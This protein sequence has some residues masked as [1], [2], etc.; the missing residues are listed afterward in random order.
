AYVTGGVSY[1][2]FETTSKAPPFEAEQGVFVLKLNPA[3]SGLDY[4]VVLG[5]GT[6]SGI[7]L[8]ALGDAYIVGYTN[9]SNFPTTVGAFQTQRRNAA[10]YLTDAFIARISERAEVRMATHVSAAN[11]GAPLAADSMI[12]AFGSKLAIGTEAALATPLP[13]TL[14]GTVVRVR[15]SAGTERGAPLFF[16]SPSQINYLMPAGTASGAATIAVVS[17]DGAV[18]TA[19]VMIAAVAPGLFTADASGRG[20]AA[21]VALR[22]KATGEQS[23]EPIAQY[24][25][26][27]NRMMPMPVNLGADLGNASEQVFLILYGTGLRHYAGLNGVSI[28]IGGVD[29]QAVYA[30]AE[31]DF[32]GLDQINVRLPRQLAGR[33]E[34]DIVL[35]VDG[36][37]ANTVK[38]WIK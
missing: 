35:I 21:A 16:V 2:T 10:A 9:G 18:S 28:K 20:L 26:A 3:G 5:D 8:S 30:G 12:A 14:V 15:D 24:D 29:A 22:V 36:K 27:Q 38:V 13:E 6:V 11:Y 23:Y 37:T 33:G 7:A 19:S 31:G 32:Y 1:Y 4:S 25:A 34:A 17:G